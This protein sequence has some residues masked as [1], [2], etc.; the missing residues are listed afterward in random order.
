MAVAGTAARTHARPR[1]R[2]HRG[3]A[4]GGAGRRRRADLCPRPRRAG[5]RER[6]H[7]RPG[8]RRVRWGSPSS[9]SACTRS[10]R[11][12]PRCSRPTSRAGTRVLPISLQDDEL[13]VAMSDP[14]NIFAIDDLR[15]VTGYEIR[16]VVSRG[17]RPRRGA[18][19]SSPPSQANVDDMVGDL[20]DAVGPSAG[21]A[22]R[23]RRTTSER[24]PSPSS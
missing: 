23:T 4:D 12:P 20:E 18:S 22:T 19:T 13:V 14:A 9:T 5:L 11:T 16:P 8:R 3:A 15:I 10:T 21:R 2:H 24:A 7:G 1:R 17:D 6:R